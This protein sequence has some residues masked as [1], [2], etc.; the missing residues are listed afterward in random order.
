MQLVST[1]LILSLSMFGFNANASE[2]ASSGGEHGSGA[3]AVEA[4]YS[5][6][7]SQEWSEVQAKLGALKSKVEAQEA[8]VNSLIAETGGG[9]GG[10][11][12]AA[13]SGG[14]HEAPSSGG[15]GSGGSAGGMNERIEQ[16]KKEHQKLQTMIVEYNKM[17]A[18]YETRFPEKGLKE[19]RIYRR[20]DPQAAITEA[21]SANYEERI[22]RLQGKI[23]RQYPKSAKDILSKKKKN[24]VV[25]SESHQSNEKAHQKNDGSHPAK[26]GDVTEQIILKK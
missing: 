11:H 26:S 22:Q 20:A 25:K 9:H 19:S 15:H 1:F 17:N 10:G 14:G 6:K 2:A 23:M 3:A 18:S 12:G 13:P 4:D 8:L 16:L 21:G 5:G 24:K 7:Q